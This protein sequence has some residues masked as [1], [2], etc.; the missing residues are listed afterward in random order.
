MHLFDTKRH[1]IWNRYLFTVHVAS[2]MRAISTDIHFRCLLVVYVDFWHTRFFRA[3]QTRSPNSV[4]RRS[5]FQSVLF[6]SS[7]YQVEFSHGFPVRWKMH[8][9]CSYA[10]SVD[11]RYQRFS[12]VRLLDMGFLMIRAIYCPLDHLLEDFKGACNIIHGRILT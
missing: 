9:S 2:K 12:D 7:T 6:L 1:I 8:L 10:Q 3:M 5:F 11:R 4:S